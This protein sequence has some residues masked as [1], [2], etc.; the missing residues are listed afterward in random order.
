MMP[1]PWHPRRLEGYGRHPPDPRWPGGARLALQ[2][3]LNVEEGAE[4][5]ILNGDEGSETYLPEFQGAR[6]L[7]GQRHLGTE[8]LYDY[9]AQVGFWRILNLFGARNLP[10]TA[11]AVGRAL[12]LQPE[13]GAALVEAR[14]E[15][16][17]HGWRWMDYREV[18]EALEREHIE[19]TCSVIARLAG[20]PPVGWYTGRVSSNTR[21]LLVERG[22]F[23][24]DSDAYDAELPYW[25]DDGRR[26]HLVIPYTLVH[27]DVRYVT[28]PGCA[29]ADDFF[30]LLRDGFDRL[31][32]EGAERPR[33]MSVGLHSRFSGH[34]AR[35][36]AI[37]RF[38]DHVASHH[39]VWICRRREIA[40]H[41]RRHFSPDLEGG[42]LPHTSWPR[43]SDG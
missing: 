18:D 19:R 29:H 34:P 10:L 12:E 39:G 5:T 27:N 20:R 7:I 28:S 13:A 42:G 9:G 3:V 35:A 16:A 6:P 33:M 4:H 41:W 43:S 17:G 25:L 23:Q 1:D 2:F 14:H 32:A 30:Q 22:H 21:R 38:L 8:S 15:I 24:Y 26:A 36:V 11:F 31:W 40:E 37:A